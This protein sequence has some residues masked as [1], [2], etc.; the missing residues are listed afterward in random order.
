MEI[1]Q[2]CILDKL[3]IAYPTKLI[4]V[5]AQTNILEFIGSLNID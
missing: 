2:M 5:K 4:P 3:I 1:K